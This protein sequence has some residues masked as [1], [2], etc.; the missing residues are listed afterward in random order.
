MGWSRGDK[1]GYLQCYLQ[2]EGC[3]LS[4]FLLAL[5]HVD[6]QTHSGTFFQEAIAMNN[7][8][9]VLSSGAACL[10]GMLHF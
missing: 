1:Q 8:A 10:V 5:Y 4:A 6:H 3:G 7:D 2:S 9:R